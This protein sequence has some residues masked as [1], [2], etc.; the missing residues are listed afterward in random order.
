MNTSRLVPASSQ[1]GSLKSS[2]RL[3]WRLLGGLAFAGLIGW[4]LVLNLDDGGK[5]QP[6]RWF[7]PQ[8]AARQCA[9]EAGITANS[10]GQAMTTGQLG[11]LTACMDRELA[12]AGM[13]P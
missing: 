10:P 7:S 4:L 8:E 13:A 1:S 3:L 12:R 6:Y 9:V 2:Q 11:L 5:A